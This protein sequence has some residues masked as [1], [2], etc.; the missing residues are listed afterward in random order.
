MCGHPL[1]R[2]TCRA[3]RVAADLLTILGF[4]RGSSAIAVH[5][6][7]RAWKTFGFKNVKLQR[8]LTILGMN[9]GSEFWGGPEALEKQGRKIRGQNSPQEFA[10]KFAGNSPKIRQ[11][12]FKNSPQI[13]YAEVTLK[14]P[15]INSKKKNPC[16][17][18]IMLVSMGIIREL[19]CFIKEPQEINTH[20]KT[21][22]TVVGRV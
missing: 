13:R 3:T 19:V 15:K 11:T 20:W 17:V 14:G 5:S 4:F 6:T 9:F 12:K 8:I 21:H 7:P 18:I 22:V 2:Y 10:E 16:K 1:S